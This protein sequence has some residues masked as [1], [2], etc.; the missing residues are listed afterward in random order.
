MPKY[1]GSNF[2]QVDRGIF[3]LSF[4]I[5]SPTACKLY[6]WLCELEH[7]FCTSDKSDYF[8]RTDKQLSEDLDMSVSTIKRAKKELI[9]LD[10]IRFGVVHWVDKNGKKSEKKVTAYTILKRG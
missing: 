7:R 10:Y 5:L 3:D 4:K 6:I 2:I 1:K 9:N 8:F